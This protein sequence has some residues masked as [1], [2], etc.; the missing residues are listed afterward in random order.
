[1]NRELFREATE[2]ILRIPWERIPLLGTDVLADCAARLWWDKHTDPVEFY[3]TSFMY[4]CH[5]IDRATGSQDPWQWLADKAREAGHITVLDYGCGIGQVGWFFQEQGFQVKFDDLDSPAFAICKEYGRMLGYSEPT[6]ESFDLI[7]CF[8]VL[9][10]VVDPV[11]T[12]TGLAE[13]LS[14][15]GWLVTLPTFG[16]SF[17]ED[18]TR[19]R[20]EHLAENDRYWGTWDLTVDREVPE[21]RIKEARGG[22]RI[23]ERKVGQNVAA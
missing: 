3:R 13:R 22:T 1:M 2:K 10:H 7:L 19:M 12:M 5:Q 21:L 15:E 16:S 23:Y 20:P 14:P 8:D 4:C 11:S 18:G 6:V 9:E 17:H